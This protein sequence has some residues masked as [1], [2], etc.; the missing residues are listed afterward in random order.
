M[1]KKIKELA[2]EVHLAKACFHGY[3]SN[4]EEPLGDRWTLFRAAP[5]WLKDS[6]PGPW[7]PDLKGLYTIDWG[8][9]FGCSEKEMCDPAELLISAHEDF[10]SVFCKDPALYNLFREAILKD[11]IGTFECPGT[12]P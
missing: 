12:R 2:K 1:L 3:I 9:E 5:H 7:I 6:V 8:D 11:N 4:I 10:D